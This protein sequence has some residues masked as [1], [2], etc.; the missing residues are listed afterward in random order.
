MRKKEKEEKRAK[1]RRRRQTQK[2]TKGKKYHTVEPHRVAD[3]RDARPPPEER[4]V[5][6]VS[7]RRPRSGGVLVLFRRGSRVGVGRQGGEEG[8]GPVELVADCEV[9]FVCFLRGNEEE[10]REKGNKERDIE[11][12]GGAEEEDK[13][14]SKDAKKDSKKKKKKK[15]TR[16]DEDVGLDLSLLFQHHALLRERQNLLRRHAQKACLLQE[17][18]PVAALPAEQLRSRPQLRRRERFD[19]GRFV[20][21]AGGEAGEAVCQGAREQDGDEE[22]EEELAG[23]GDDPTVGWCFVSGARKRRKRRSERE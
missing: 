20:K 16:D 11:R 1:R 2:K 23:E 21:G 19:A 9:F 4:E 14:S 22:D 8:R 5:V 6:E 17:E 18:P 10:K 13:A 15:L 3:R 12:E 7:Q